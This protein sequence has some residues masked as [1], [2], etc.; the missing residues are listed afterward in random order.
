MDLDNMLKFIEVEYNK[1]I[2]ENN[3]ANEN[4]ESIYR[5]IDAESIKNAIREFGIDINIDI[6][7]A[8]KIRLQSIE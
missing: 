8:K 2:N 5:N 7:T 1:K 6:D 4:T 3:S